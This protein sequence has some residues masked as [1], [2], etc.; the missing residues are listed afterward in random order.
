MDV[1]V[2]V[3][4]VPD[5]VEWWILHFRHALLLRRLCRRPLLSRSPQVQSVQRPGGA[6]G[7]AVPVL[8]PVQSRPV[9]PVLQQSPAP[10]CQATAQR[11]PALPRQQRTQLASRTSHHLGFLAASYKQ[12]NNNVIDN[13]Y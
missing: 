4:V 7:P 2:E 1:H 8:F 12:N 6:A 9:V 5:A 10:L 3:Q 13:D 11:V